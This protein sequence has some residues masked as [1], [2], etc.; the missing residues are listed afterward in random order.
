MSCYDI[1]HSSLNQS[2]NG[3]CDNDKFLFSF[4]HEC[5][6]ILVKIKPYLA[7]SDFCH[8]AK[9]FSLKNKGPMRGKAVKRICI[10]T[11]DDLAFTYMNI[12]SLWNTSQ[13]L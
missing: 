2:K 3:N 7:L 4:L 5:L 6:F 8:N 10:Y 9:P 13:I 1:P 11:E 12:S